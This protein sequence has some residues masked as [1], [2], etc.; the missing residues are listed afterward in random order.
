LQNNVFEQLELPTEIPENFVYF[1][2]SP[3][4]SN[5]CT[6]TTS[7]SNVT[8]I[9]KSKRLV[10]SKQ[11]PTIPLPNMFLEPITERAKD[12]FTIPVQ[13]KKSKVEH[14]KFNWVNGNKVDFE[15]NIPDYD[16][17]YLNKIMY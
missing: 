13:K 8:P 15:V 5:L 17:V 10:S 2:H 12:S 16:Y 11:T 14:M 1:S 3:P 9:R 4:E 7:G 6:P